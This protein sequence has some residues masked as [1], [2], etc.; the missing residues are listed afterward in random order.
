MTVTVRLGW[1]GLAAAPTASVARPDS[2]NQVTSAVSAP[3]LLPMKRISGSLADAAN[4]VT[5]GPIVAC[6]ALVGGLGDTTVRPGQIPSKA[7][8]AGVAGVP[9]SRTG[10]T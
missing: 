9:A 4:V 6:Q 5:I 8:S 1:V 2:S 3:P 7:G 10:R